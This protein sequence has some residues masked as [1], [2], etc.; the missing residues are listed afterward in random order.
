MNSGVKMSEN[1]SIC[2]VEDQAILREALVKLLHE[3]MPDAS[4]IEAQNGK[5]ALDVVRKNPPDIILMD[6]QLPDK[7]G[8]IVTKTITKK[9]EHVKII[10]FS[11]HKDIEYLRAMLVAG[12]VGYINK[13]NFFDE[14]IGGIQRVADGGYYFSDDMLATLLEDYCDLLNEMEKT[15][16]NQMTPRELDVLRL[17]AVGETSS[18]IANDLDITTKT[19][20]NQRQSLMNKLN[21][22]NI[23]GLTR[24]ALKHGIIE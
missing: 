20:E 15:V 24:Y 10:A 14:L 11:E 8:I 1:R 5:E 6:I 13:D 7:S 16:F 17:I 9:F 4:I 12:A 2:I 19:V 22:H 3:S 18:E 23:A 21:I